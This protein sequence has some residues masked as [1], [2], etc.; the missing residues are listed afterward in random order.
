MPLN[1]RPL[2]RWR[3]PAANTSVSLYCVPHA[4][5]GAGSLSRFATEMPPEWDLV[6][7][8]LPGR[9]IRLAEQPLA[10][11][12]GVVAEVSAAVEADSLRPPGARVVLLGQCSGC[13]VAFEVARRLLDSDVAPAALIVVSRGAPDVPVEVPDPDAV[14]DRFLDEMEIVGGLAPE[15]R[16]L[17]EAVDL[18]LPALR[19]DVRAVRGFSRT[20]KDRLPV[21]VLA[22][23]GSADKHC[24][25]EQVSAWRAFG[26][27]ASRYDEVPGGHL[28]L[29]DS[30]TPVARAI[31]G[32]GLLP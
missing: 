24:T 32:A 26:S 25:V 7:V 27:T 23:R 9:E 19:A 4:G 22:I 18:M 14:E 20:P 13:V 31:V 6:G 2:A 8:R 5:A 16:I 28:L 21:P 1:S 3:E 15:L 17:P 11:L 30:P 29:A 12:A 10:D